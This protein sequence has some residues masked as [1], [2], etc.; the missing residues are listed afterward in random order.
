MA[1]RALDAGGNGYLL[2][3]SAPND[4][5]S[6]IEAAK[7]GGV[8]LSPEIAAHLVTA[9]H[10]QRLGG[11]SKP[12]ARLSEREMEVL[13][14][15]AEG[16]RNKEIAERF[17]VSIKSVE[18]YRRRMMAKLGCSSTAELIRH[19]IRAGLIAP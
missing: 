15:I 17:K 14:L 19:A 6:A 3:D 11:A 16:L 18:T 10:G 1:R 8:F 9:D 2:K 7:K 5:A 12:S 13:R 4:L